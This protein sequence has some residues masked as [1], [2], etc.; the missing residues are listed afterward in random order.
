MSFECHHQGEESGPSVFTRAIWTMV[1]IPRVRLFPDS[2]RAFCDILGHRD[3]CRLLAQSVPPGLHSGTV[4]LKLAPHRPA[5]GV[6]ACRNLQ[7]QR[8]IN[9]AKNAQLARLGRYSARHIP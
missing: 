1:S 4:V 8:E 6:C 7:T 3:T 9:L 5:D 2:R